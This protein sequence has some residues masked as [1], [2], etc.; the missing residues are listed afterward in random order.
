MKNKV[1]EYGNRL[2]GILRC[3]LNCEYHEFGVKANDNLRL[4][5]K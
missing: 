4:I 3:Y 2:E 5:V 1:L